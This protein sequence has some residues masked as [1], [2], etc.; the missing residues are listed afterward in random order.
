MQSYHR[1]QQ[2]QVAAR[3]HGSA[4]D[5]EHERASTGLQVSMA[6]WEAARRLLGMPPAGASDA[7]A[8]R[9]GGGAS[10]GARGRVPSGRD[11]AEV[12]P[13]AEVVAQMRHHAELTVIMCLHFSNAAELAIGVCERQSE[14]HP[15]PETGRLLQA[16][17][18]RLV[19][20]ACATFG[21]GSRGKLPRGNL[22]DCLQ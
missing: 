20:E 9:K 11:H 4:A 15:D 6:D 8:R 18:A 19:H 5:A 16:E 10:R 21:H 17:Q 14:P 7:G 12:Q 2:Q 3:A 22:E 1:E 13:V